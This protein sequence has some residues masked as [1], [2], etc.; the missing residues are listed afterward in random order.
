MPQITTIPARIFLVE[1]HALMRRQLSAIIDR[2]PDLV[3]CGEAEDVSTA[4]AGIARC[5]PD[6]V[7][8]DLFLKDSNGFE[9]LKELQAAYPQLPVLVMSLHQPK[10]FANRS[11][12]AGARGFITKQDAVHHLL[13]AIQMVLRGG[14][15]SHAVPTQ[16]GNRPVA[17]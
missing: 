6:L 11:L 10:V 7:L 12:A 17:K 2:A 9:L 3:V 14:I 16:P 4:A 15:Y 13:E 5:S 1:D 8:M